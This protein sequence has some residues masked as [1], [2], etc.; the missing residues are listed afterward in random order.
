MSDI[1]ESIIKDLYELDSTLR[2]REGEVRVIVAA[3]LARKPQVV[4][5]GSFAR[6]LRQAL[7]ATDSTGVSANIGAVASPFPWQWWTVRLLPFGAV[8]LLF[9]MLIPSQTSYAPGVDMYEP[10]PAVSEEIGLV[11]PVGSE[12]MKRSVP[13]VPPTRSENSM[14]LTADESIAVESVPDT[15]STKMLM[16][17]GSLSKGPLKL[18]SS[19]RL[20]PLEVMVHSMSDAS[21]FIVAR[22]VDREGLGTIIAI[23][24]FLQEVFS[25]SLTLSQREDLQTG[26]TYSIGIYKDNQ[27]SPK[28]LRW[29]HPD[30][31]ILMSEIR[32]SVDESGMFTIQL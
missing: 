7:L 11:N 4:P 28:D 16:V 17:P 29:F 3:L 26:A 22:K 6:D 18:L 10:V 14:I 24:P 23:S 8:A 30:S 2:E 32:F 15:A 25:G 20:E 9:F 1:V 5:D 27:A 31:D 21:G 19:H 13:A 12:A